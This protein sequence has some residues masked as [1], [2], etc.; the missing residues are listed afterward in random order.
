VSAREEWLDRFG[1]ALRVGGRARRRALAE[2]AAHVEDAAAARGDREALARMGDPVALAG[3]IDAEV[4]VRLARRSTVA[5]VAGLVAAAAG[6]VA[7]ANT[8]PATPPAPFLQ[9]LVLFVGAQLAA[10][11][12]ALAALQS[13]AGARGPALL[14]RR[15]RV[16]A[17]AG[18]CALG[19]A[20]PVA[21]AWSTAMLSA[22]ALATLAAAWRAATLARIAAPAGDDPVAGD[23]FADAATLLPPLAGPLGRARS[24]LD[25]RVHPVR[26]CAVVA[27]LAATAATLRDHGEHDAWPLAL[28]FGALEALAVTG[29]FATLGHRLG[30]RR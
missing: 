11:A 14:A 5:V 7:L 23:P 28:L 22:A 4:A 29:C 1:A 20:L 17:A 30:L 2:V 21:A 24:L 13:L 6:V 18:A 26:C 15:V 8:G 25:P 3:A 19:A 9:G 16:A 10:V 12:A 27:A